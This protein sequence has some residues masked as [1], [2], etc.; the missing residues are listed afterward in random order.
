MKHESL[1]YA[2]AALL[3]ALIHPTESQAAKNRN[4]SVNFDDNANHCSDLKVKSNAELAQAT[5]SFN[6]R[7]SEAPTLELNGV[8][9]GS[10]R[11]MGWDSQDYAVEACKIVV[12]DDR[13]SAE[14]MLRSISVTRAAGHISSN[15]PNS[16]TAEWQVYFIVH[17]PK[18]A[19]LDLETKNGPISVRDITGNVKVRATNGPLALDNVSGTVQARTVNGPISYSGTGGDVHINAQNGPLSVKLTGD[20]WNGPQLEARTVNGPVSLQIPDTFQSGVR[21]ESNGNAPMS[22]R[23]AACRNAWTDSTRDDRHVMRLNGSG[24]AVRV[25]TGNGP[26]SIGGPSKSKSVI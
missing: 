20:L 9:R 11:V 10:I 21:I 12:G 5:E 2:A 13:A 18:D 17:A 14:Q 8:D 25:S 22:C 1:Y 24:D 19:S 4:L 6:F 3:C 23:I 15:G 26:I 7:K 16:D